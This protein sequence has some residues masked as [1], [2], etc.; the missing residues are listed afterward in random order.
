MRPPFAA[1]LVAPAIIEN[2]PPAPV[3]PSPLDNVIDPPAP[4]VADPDVI[5]TEP[6][7]P[8]E[9]SPVF[10]DTM[11]LTPAAPALADDTLRSPLVDVVP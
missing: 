3:S 5:K 8:A 4:P 10:T 9:E 1:A 7:V 6:V 11:P 2:S